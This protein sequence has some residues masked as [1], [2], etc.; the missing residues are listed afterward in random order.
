MSPHVRRRPGSPFLPP[1]VLEGAALSA[2]REREGGRGG[3]PALPRPLSTLGSGWVS[4]RPSGR[5]GRAPAVP[6]AQPD[7]GPGRRRLPARWKLARNR[8]GGSAGGGAR[9]GPSRPGHPGRC[10][11]IA[12]EGAAASRRVSVWVPGMDG[13]GGLVGSQ[14]QGLPSSSCVGNVPL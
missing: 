10:G 6:P 11:G 8:R 13:V 9:P 5:A 1:Q 3:G 7:P 12:P 2:R 14:P 4:D